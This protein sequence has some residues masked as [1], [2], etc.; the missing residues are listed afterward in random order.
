MRKRSEMIAIDATRRTDLPP[1]SMDRRGSV[2]VSTWKNA[3]GTNLLGV[4]QNAARKAEPG[5]ARVTR[6][7]S[8][9]PRL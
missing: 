2:Q 3:S 4:A 8:L 1:P 9:E 5:G 7:T 6:G